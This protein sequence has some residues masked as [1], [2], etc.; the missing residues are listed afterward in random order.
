MGKRRGRILEP[1]SRV[2]LVA[3]CGPPNP[4]RL[5]AGLQVIQ[6]WGLQWVAGA[7]VEAHLSGTAPAC[8]LDFLSAPDCDRLDELHWGLMAPEI[9]ACWVVRGGHGLGRILAGLRAG[10]GARPVLGFSDVTALHQVL[11]LQGWTSLVHAANVQTLAFL[12]AGAQEALRGL[13]LEGRVGR[14]PGHWL[15]SPKT[16]SGVLWGGNLCVLASLCGSAGWVRNEGG[17]LFLE[18]LNESPYRIDRLLQQLQN[19][20]VFD[21]LEAIVLGQFTDCGRLD[22]LWSH[23]VERWGLPV[24]AGIPSGHEADNYPLPLG[25]EVEIVQSHL[26]W[27]FRST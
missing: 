15:T 2:G 5:R 16:V 12:D 26:S 25:E 8:E 14:L 23:W 21:T 6:S 11:R 24:F 20:R 7:V 27:R 13:L 1:G 19:S 17:I 22:A 10:P 3:P 9:D 4:E 18:D